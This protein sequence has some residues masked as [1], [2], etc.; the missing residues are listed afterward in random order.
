MDSE[1]QPVT[2]AVGAVVTEAVDHDPAALPDAQL[3]RQH[4]ALRRPRLALAEH[5][6]LFQAQRV[7]QRRLRGGIGPARPTPRGLSHGTRG[8][9]D[10][11]TGKRA[12]RADRPLGAAAPRRRG[13][14]CGDGGY[15]EEIGRGGRRFGSNLQEIRTPT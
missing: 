13:G 3:A 15:R 14:G 11:A 1:V 9:R 2:S 6:V 12:A 7:A 5:G 4:A 10:H 8:L